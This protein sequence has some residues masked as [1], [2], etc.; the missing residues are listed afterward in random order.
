MSTAVRPLRRPTRAPVTDTPDGVGSGADSEVSATCETSKS[1]PI[2]EARIPYPR[3][4]KT[5]GQHRGLREELITI[6]TT[7]RTW[8]PQRPFGTHPAE[9]RRTS[10]LTRVGVR[11]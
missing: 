4:Q 8:R 11:E 10:E 5:H 2:C 9:P 6:R 3:A 1:P 7:F